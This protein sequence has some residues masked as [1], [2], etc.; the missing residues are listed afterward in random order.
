MYPIVN[1]GACPLL[2]VIGPRGRQTTGW[3]PRGPGDVQ[4]FP[5]PVEWA[6]EDWE[7]LL[8][9]L[10]EGDNPQRAIEAQLLSGLA[11]GDPRN[12]C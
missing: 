6:H 8:K 5:Q 4:T 10:R 9:L 11:K 7:A 3:P 12:G 2:L 1:T